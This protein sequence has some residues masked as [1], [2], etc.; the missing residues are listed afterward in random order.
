LARTAAK[1]A[2]P[3]PATQGIQLPW[4]SDAANW[5]W[6]EYYETIQ[7]GH[8]Q[9]CKTVQSAD[10]DGDGRDVLLAR[11]PAGL[12]AVHYDPASGQWLQ[13][14]DGRPYSDTNGWDGARFF[15]TIQTA[16]IDGDGAAE[17]IARNTSGIEAW[18]YDPVNLV[19][20][21]LPSGPGWSDT[22]AWNQ[23]ENF[24]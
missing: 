7:A 13:M 17:L 8:R 4:W 15:Q 5:N 14:P 16:D 11:S 1:A 2:T 18:K 19:W 9:S 10:I 20:H 21:Q 24:M 23:A 12:L 22:D 3:N 6:Y